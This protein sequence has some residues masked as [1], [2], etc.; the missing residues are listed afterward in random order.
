MPN[1]SLDKFLYNKTE[2]ILNW[3]QR[4]KIIEDVALALTYLHE[5]WAEVIIHRD[6]KASNVLLDGE[7]N[8]K[9]GDFGLA[10][11]IEHEQDIQTTHIAGTLGYIAPELARSI[12]QVFLKNYCIKYIQVSLC[13]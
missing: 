6:I 10:R 12:F 7:L 11:C 5:E 13:G 3:N 4:F 8:A 2:F 1:G 9:L